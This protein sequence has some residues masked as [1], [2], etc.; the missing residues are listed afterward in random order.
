MIKEKKVRQRSEQNLM[1][2]GH[3]EIIKQIEKDLKRENERKMVDLTMKYR[4][5]EA[6]LDNDLEELTQK[7][8]KVYK[9]Y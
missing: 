5:H 6:E 3:R 7:I 1:H 9:K 4:R 8:I 2:T